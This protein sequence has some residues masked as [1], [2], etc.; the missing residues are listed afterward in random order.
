MSV[1]KHTPQ[2]E[3]RDIPGFP[4]YRAGSDGTLWSC[5]RG[6]N[7]S[8]TLRSTWSQMQPKIPIRDYWCVSICYNRH[9]R[10]I[11]VHRLILLAFLGPAPTDRHECRH[12]N[13]DK[14]DNRIENL[15]WGTRAEN[16]HDKIGHG[17][18]RI[19]VNHPMSKLTDA[20]VRELRRLWEA[21]KPLYK[22][23]KKFR[24]DPMT[25]KAAVTRH[26]WRHVL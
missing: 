13:G 1:V 5:R 22:L 25:I 14:L 23:A 3:Y 2:V 4:G 18:V 7:G 20:K 6:L 24:V 17:T 8:Q 9:N 16:E 15:Q 26:T 19:G 10:C 21:G 12:L 11:R